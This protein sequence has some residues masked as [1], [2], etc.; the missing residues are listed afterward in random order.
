MNC[1]NKRNVFDE[2]FFK[3]D[4]D[5]FF[6]NN[7]IEIIKSE[8]MKKSLLKKKNLVNSEK[9]KDYHFFSSNRSPRE[10]QTICKMQYFY[11]STTYRNI[12]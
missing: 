12:V 8:G 10:A 3:L 6:L 2:F 7:V 4:D 1:I 9:F 5:E 11:F